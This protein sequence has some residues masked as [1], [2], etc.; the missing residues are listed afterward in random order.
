[1]DRLA[2]FGS[3]CAL[4]GCLM[5][6]PSVSLG[7]VWP[8]PANERQVWAEVQRQLEYERIGYE[9]TAITRNHCLGRDDAGGGGQDD[10]T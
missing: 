3:L 4:T 2:F 6:L 1:M 5:A 10:K 7:T 9:L 8:R